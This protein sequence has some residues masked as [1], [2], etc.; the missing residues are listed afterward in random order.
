M[1]W[2]EEGGCQDS[3]A[4]RIKAGICVV[5]SAAM[6]LVQ[7][8]RRLSRLVVALL[9]AAVL[10]ASSSQPPG[11]TYERARQFTRNIEFDYVS[12]IFDAL[13]V[14]ANQIAL[15][16][17]NYISTGQSHETVLEYV[18]LVNNLQQAQAQ[19]NDIYAD[20]NVSDPKNASAD[21]PKQIADLKARRR[22][23]GPL[24]E[25]I[26]QSQ[27]GSEAAS[28]GLTLG[29]QPVPPVMYHSTPLPQALIIS[30]RD[31][32]R[33][34][35]DIS[36]VPDLTVA[37]SAELE[38]NVD[39]ALDVSSLV[40]GIGGV[41]V[42]PTMV[43]QTGDLNWLCETVAHE[44]THNFLTMRPLGVNYY[45]SPEL[46]TMNETAATIAGKEIGSAVIQRYYPELAPKPPPAEKPGGE[47][48]TGPAIPVFDF[49]SEMHTTRLQV[50]AL[51]AD[52]KIKEAQDYMEARRVFLWDHGYHIRKLNQ[53]Y[54]AFF[55]AYADQPGGAA[56]V[57]P[58][59]AAVRLLR[60]GSPNLAVF[61]NRISW[62]WSFGQLQ[63]AVS[64][65]V[66]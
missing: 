39:Q 4:L 32:I 47:T 1:G 26:L 52:G 53:A 34:D 25:A 49:R 5:E 48:E 20:P 45:K 64:G 50:D 55:G 56:G 59:G 43:A 18:D 10:L 38:D 42:Y 22:Q 51:L 61:L 27:I 13:W 7:I 46:R 63:Q 36:L 2:I 12:W 3:R 41:G 44:W 19:L 28:M 66:P 57:D 9:V 60:A 17:N 33:Q 58:V 30:P 21:L 24:A 6:K 37:Q 8:L 29:G 23:I 14:K 16:T 11:D 31:V 62:M 15:G 40:V 35:A 54:F 65:M